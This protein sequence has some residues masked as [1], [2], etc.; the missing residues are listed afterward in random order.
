MNSRRTPGLHGEVNTRSTTQIFQIIGF[1]AHATAVIVCP[2]LRPM[3]GRRDAGYYLPYEYYHRPMTE[4]C[5][6]HTVVVV[7]SPLDTTKATSASQVYGPDASYDKVGE[8]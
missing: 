6:C 5:R 2:H 7:G 4:W 3:H 8:G 1:T